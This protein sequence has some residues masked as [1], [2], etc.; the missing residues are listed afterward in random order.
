[1]FLVFFSSLIPWFS[2]S[3]SNWWTLSVL[4]CI[5]NQ[6]LEFVKAI[7]VTNPYV[8]H[9]WFYIF[10]FTSCR[11]LE[12]K[13]KESQVQIY[14]SNDK[15]FYVLSIL[16]IYHSEYIM[17]FKYTKY[18]VSQYKWDKEQ[19]LPRKSL[20]SSSLY[21]NSCVRKNKIEQK[22]SLKFIATEICLANQLLVRIALDK[23][24]RLGF[25]IF[26]FGRVSSKLSQGVSFG[27]DQKRL[28]S[29]FHILRTTLPCLKHTVL[30]CSCIRERHVPWVRTLVHCIKV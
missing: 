21:S 29:C 10:V 6:L 26:T 3:N 5:N 13:V 7:V 19:N 22:L 8:H 1:M 23:H 18:E 20:L 9:L 4:I 30:Q 11:Q 2:N 16:I 28:L 15:L 24:S 17:Y 27:T 12:K 14:N 25:L